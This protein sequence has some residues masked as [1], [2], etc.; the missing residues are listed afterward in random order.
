MGFFDSGPD[1]PALRMT[2]S[3][4]VILSEAKDPINLER[5]NHVYQ[6]RHQ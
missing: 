4:G 3:S 5:T 1:G 6:H 2:Q